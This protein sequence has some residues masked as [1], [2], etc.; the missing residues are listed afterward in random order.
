MHD[1]SDTSS[2][3]L[4]PGILLTVLLMRADMPLTRIGLPGSGAGS[5]PSMGAKVG[6]VKSTIT[7]NSDTPVAPIEKQP[8]GSARLTRVRVVV[9]GKPPVKFRL[10]NHCTLRIWRNASGVSEMM[11]TII[12]VPCGLRAVVLQGVTNASSTDDPHPMEYCARAAGS[13]AASSRAAA[14]RAAAA[15]EGV[16][17]CGADAALLCRAGCV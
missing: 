11:Q 14:A 8:Q 12:R 2:P 15:R 4:P 13:A 9:V 17:M 6:K 7:G 16:M 1:G 10:G 3:K 5:T